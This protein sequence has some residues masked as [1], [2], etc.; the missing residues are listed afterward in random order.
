[1]TRILIADD[2]PIIVSGLRAIL[3]GTD[4]EVVGAVSRG[5]EVPAAIEALAPDILLLD[6]SMPGL[7]GVE[8][9]R[10]LRGQGDGRTVVLLTAG[11][12][13]AA[14]IEAV[15]LGVNGI[16]LK[17]GAHALLISCL[18]AVRDGQRWI[19]P[20]LLQR[21]LDLS[22]GGGLPV[23]PLA[24]LSERERAI[25]GL[26]VRGLRNREIAERLQMN[27]GTVKVY[28]HRVYKKLGVGSRTE[29]LLHAHGDR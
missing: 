27:E 22:L 9:L 14:L 20:A 5:D 4:Y 6:V 29:L 15:Q 16:V 11:L 21:A 13:D 12:D 19:E 24:T 18:D 2:H 7:G 26:V 23:D 17:E 1:M 8:L 10:A 28:L 25:A 3:A